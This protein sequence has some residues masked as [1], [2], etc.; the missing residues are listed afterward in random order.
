M[1]LYASTK[2]KDPVLQDIAVISATACSW[3]ICGK[4]SSA[5]MNPAVVLASHLTRAI[6]LGEIYLLKQTLLYL[7]SEYISVHISIILYNNYLK[8]I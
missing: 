3:S 6:Y 4:F 7:V 8:Y 1:I 5:G 2:I